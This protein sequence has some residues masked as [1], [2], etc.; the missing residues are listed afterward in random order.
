[1]VLNTCGN[2][3]CNG[4]EHTK[5]KFKELEFIHHYL[6]K[7]ISVPI[8]IEYGIFIYCYG[9]SSYSS[10]F[11]YYRQENDPARPYD[12]VVEFYENYQREQREKENEESSEE[13]ETSEE[14]Q[15]LEDV[16]NSVNQNPELKVLN[17][18][19]CNIKTKTFLSYMGTDK[20]VVIPDGIKYIEYIDEKVSWAFKKADIKSIKIPQSVI[21]IDQFAFKN[22][23]LK[24]FQAP[25][26]KRLGFQ[27]FA[28]TV[29]SHLIFPST[30]K[31]IP[32]CSFRAKINKV[33]I[34]EG[35]E[36][37]ESDAFNGAIIK[38]ISIPKTI[39]HIG[40]FAIPNYT[41]VIL[42]KGISRYEIRNDFLYDKK[43]NRC[44]AFCGKKNQIAHIPETT[45]KFCILKFPKK[46]SIPAKLSFSSLIK[47]NYGTPTEIYLQNGRISLPPGAFKLCENLEK[48]VLPKTLKSIPFQSF[49]SLSLKQIK[50]PEN[51]TSIAGEAFA[52]CDNLESI[53]LPPRLKKISH[54]L[55]AECKSLKSI[56]ISKSVEE[57]E[58][59]AFYNCES[60]K[61][62]KLPKNL[63][64]IGYRAFYG[65]K[66]LRE[67]GIPASV[68]EIGADAFNCDNLILIVKRDSYAAKWAKEN[69]M[70]YKEK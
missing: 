7:Y 41:K 49:F 56:V 35:C 39:K 60:L 10:I 1:M 28:N 29:I 18:C 15:E 62:I 52:F 30:L 45:K 38:K 2:Y 16:E 63:E 64:K 25:G 65:C 17:G 70:K 20:N 69:G 66:N 22:L 5:S 55:F 68:K 32:T 34:K 59:G 50:I 6:L 26:L 46:V 43:R 37:I 3:V 67:I 9:L 12:G 19:L 33:T 14:V 11:F 48:I 54:H 53:V 57:I 42:D 21:F 23:K 58:M 44:I 61:S 31:I 8:M 24:E 13:D 40:D 27:A 47:S 4:G 51:V 36:V